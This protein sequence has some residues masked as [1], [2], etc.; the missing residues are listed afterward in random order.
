MALLVLTPLNAVLVYVKRNVVVQ[1]DKRLE[2]ERVIIVVMLVHVMQVTTNTTINVILVHMDKQVL[3]VHKAAV[4]AIHPKKMT[5]LLV[6]RLFNVKATYANPNVATTKVVQ[7]VQLHVTMMVMLVFVVQVTTETIGNAKVV[8]T[9][10]QVVQVRKVAV[11]VI[12]PKKM[13]VLRVL[14]L[15]NVKATYANRNVATSKAFHIATI[16]I[17]E[18]QTLAQVTA[19]TFVVIEIALI[20]DQAIIV[21][22]TLHSERILVHVIHL[23]VVEYVKIIFLCVQIVIAVVLKQMEQQLLV[24]LTLVVKIMDVRGT[25]S[26]KIFIGVMF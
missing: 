9:V 11:I 25:R 16:T 26:Q 22:D 10:K 3:W 6:P 24:L 15:V 21:K 20:V 17:M 12:Y 4:L 7:Q 23:I 13:T 8:K 2:P 5:V 1:K 19:V 18:I 14:R